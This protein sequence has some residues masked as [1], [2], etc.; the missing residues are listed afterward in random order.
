MTI[1]FRKCKFDCRE[2]L[3]PL[4]RLLESTQGVFLWEE[5]VGALE[6][7]WGDWGLDLLNAS[8]AGLLAREASRRDIVGVDMSSTMI[9]AAAKWMDDIV[10]ENIFEYCS[11]E[12]F[13]VIA[14]FLDPQ[15][16]SRSVL[17]SQGYYRSIQ[18]YYPRIFI[19][20][21]FFRRG[22]VFYAVI[23]YPESFSRV[24]YVG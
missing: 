11:A 5:I 16:L 18:N 7:G 23:F 21:D 1:K 15:N 22:V 19:Y 10:P 24:N 3:L 14:R 12:L 4:R 17:S 6:L 20:C 8:C 2:I 9:Q 13:D